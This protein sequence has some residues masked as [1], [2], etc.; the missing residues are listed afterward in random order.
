[1]TVLPK[2]IH[3]FNAIPIRLLMAFFLEIEQKIS[4]FIRKHKRPLMAEVVLRKKNGAG[5]IILPDF[6]LYYKTTVIKTVQY[7]HKNK[8][9]D[10]WNKIE[11][12]K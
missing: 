8:N 10:Q 11:T 6:R 9:I 12:Q 1:M 7:W 4:Q 2:A 5:R 3:R